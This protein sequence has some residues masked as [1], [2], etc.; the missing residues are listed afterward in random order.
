M[1]GK[2]R[3]ERQR[4]PELLDHGRAGQD[5][6][7]FEALARVD[8]DVGPVVEEHPPGPRTRTGRVA[9]PRRPYGRFG[10]FD[11]ADARDPQV[12]PLDRVVAVAVAVE[13]LVLVV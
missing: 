6:A 4:G 10:A 3:V 12:D 9:V 8:R 2:A 13:A 1:G 7:R 5:V 11:R